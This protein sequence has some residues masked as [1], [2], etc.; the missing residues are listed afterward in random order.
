MLLFRGIRLREFS[1]LLPR[2]DYSE[3]KV[4]DIVQQ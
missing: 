3:G 1:N 4:F 2:N